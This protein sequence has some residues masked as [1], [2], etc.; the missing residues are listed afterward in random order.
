MNRTLLALALALIA[1]GALASRAHAAEA[2]PAQEPS[3]GCPKAEPA[4]EKAAPADAGSSTARPGATAPVRPRTNT[5]TRG[6]PRWHSLLPG[7]I[8]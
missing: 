1:T 2:E 5:G 6:A 3:V 4:E 7:M 8:R